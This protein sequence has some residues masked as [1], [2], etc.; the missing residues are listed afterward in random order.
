MIAPLI[1]EYNFQ[2]VGLGNLTRAHAKLPHLFNSPEYSGT[3]TENITYGFCNLE[4]KPMASPD[5]G[6]QYTL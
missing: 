5:Q 3:W 4:S 6:I 2:P 1:V